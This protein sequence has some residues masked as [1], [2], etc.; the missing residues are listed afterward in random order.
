MKGDADV[1]ILMEYDLRAEEKGTEVVTLRGVP[2]W[3]RRTFGVDRGQRGNHL[4]HARHRPTYH[5]PWA[6]N[7]PRFG[8]LRAWLARLSLRQACPSAAGLALIRFGRH[9]STNYCTCVRG[10]LPGSSQEAARIQVR[11]QGSA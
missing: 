2:R 1:P 11:Y 10:L 3:W 6:W 4:K 7:A 5:W 9:D 8:D